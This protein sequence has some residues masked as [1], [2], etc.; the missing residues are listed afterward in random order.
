MSGRSDWN[1]GGRFTGNVEGR[2]A[3]GYWS[4]PKATYDSESCATERLGSHYWGRFI[5]TANSDWSA[6][7]TLW[8]YC[9]KEPSRGWS[10][11]RLSAPRSR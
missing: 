9:D 11:K 10:A 8:Q 5:T 6:F 7:D 2:R 4:Q 1:G 3:A